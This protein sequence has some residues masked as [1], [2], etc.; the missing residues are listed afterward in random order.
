M[1]FYIYAAGSEIDIEYAY[2]NVKICSN[3]SSKIIAELFIKN[4]SELPIHQ[5]II[6]YPNSFINKFNPSEFAILLS[7]QRIENLTRDFTKPDNVCNDHYNKSDYKSITYS[8]G[9]VKI[10]EVNHEINEC[11]IDIEHEGIVAID[12]DFRI[13]GEEGVF[14]YLDVILLDGAKITPIFVD[15]K[16]AIEPNCTCAFKFFFNPIKTC[17]PN[18][19]SIIQN[20]LSYIRRKPLY[21]QIYS[22]INIVEK[23]EEDI[24][25][26]MDDMS[27]NKTSSLSEVYPDSLNTIKNILIDNGIKKQG[28][29]TNIIDWRIIVNFEKKIKLAKISS[30]GDIKEL[31]PFPDIFIEQDGPTEIYEYCSGSRYF[32]KSMPKYRINILVEKSSF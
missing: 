31:A 20:I 1:C 15:C 18:D 10:A 3:G 32:D 13:Y 7:E 22:P 12:S 19:T 11:P 16:P 25:S 9:V 29:K 8:N 6:L 30:S 23:M 21:F 4:R 28:T 14:E 27:K 17:L 26:F 2:E 5:F 24:N